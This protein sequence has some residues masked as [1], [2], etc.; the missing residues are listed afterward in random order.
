MII[1]DEH[2]TTD[3]VEMLAQM[4]AVVGRNGFDKVDRHGRIIELCTAREEYL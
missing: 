1:I 4:L 2:Y 3:D